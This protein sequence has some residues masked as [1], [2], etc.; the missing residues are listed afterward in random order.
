MKSLGY[1][2]LPLVLVALTINLNA[3]QDQTSTEAT[4][5]SSAATQNAPASTQDFSGT[6]FLGAYD[7]PASEQQASEQQSNDQQSSEQQVSQQS[8]QPVPG[9]APVLGHPLDPAD[10]DTLTGKNDQRRQVGP[11]GGAYYGYPMTT[12]WFS[13][14][15]FGTHFWGT[16]NGRFSSPFMFG[17]FGRNF[18]GRHFRNYGPNTVFFAPPAG[19]SFFL[20][21]PHFATPG[22]FTPGRNW[23]FGV[24]PQANVTGSPFGPRHQP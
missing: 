23:N 8:E 14:P 20:G 13:T 16:P 17:S 9:A 22:V 5:P 18:G 24:P 4:Y 10:V 11:A 7:Q 3:Q 19:T 12:D 1:F 21:G 6:N 15:Q 2:V